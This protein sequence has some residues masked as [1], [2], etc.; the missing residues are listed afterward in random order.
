MFRLVENGIDATETAVPASQPG[1]HMRLYIDTSN[2]HNTGIAFA[3]PG[4]TDLTINISMVS[5]D[6]VPAAGSQAT[7]TLPALGHIAKYIGELVSWDAGLKGVV[8]ISASGPLAVSTQR[9]LLNQRGEIL[10]T[11]LPVADLSQPP[12][13][14]I[15]PQIA[16][17]GGFKTEIIL[18]SPGTAPVSAT[19]QNRFN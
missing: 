6:G 5:M 3:N 9:T 2:G 19:L 14:P 4:N 16:D 15:F 12:P 11:S 10:L 17:G 13:M 8:E 7:L 18:I 1:T